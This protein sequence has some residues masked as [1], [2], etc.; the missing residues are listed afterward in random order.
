M[1]SKHPQISAH[2]DPIL[3]VTDSNKGPVVSGSMSQTYHIDSAYWN[4]GMHAVYALPHSRFPLAHTACRG[5]TPTMA[6]SSTVQCH[7]TA[8]TQPARG[9]FSSECTEAQR[10]VPRVHELVP[11]SPPHPW[12]TGKWYGRLN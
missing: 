12:R 9:F 5:L 6:P 8:V 7:I 10:S 11:L 2:R 4:L 1:H 3:P